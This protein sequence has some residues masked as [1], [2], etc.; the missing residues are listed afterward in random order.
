[1]K[2]KREKDCNMTNYRGNKEGEL[3]YAFQGKPYTYFG[4]EVPSSGIVTTCCIA[5]YKFHR[6]HIVV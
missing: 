2:R 5:P 6:V 3:G 1:M 4:H